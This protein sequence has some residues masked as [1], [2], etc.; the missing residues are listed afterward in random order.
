MSHIL[1]NLFFALRA[2]ADIGILENK[3]R[4]SKICY[5]KVAHKAAEATAEFIGNK[6]TDK[7][8]KPKPLPNANS[9]NV[10]EVVVP[11]EKRDEIRKSIIK[12]NTC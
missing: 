9:R 1:Q 10:E 2:K 5:L 12:W 8:L 3:T 6:I 4:C 11:P 7:M